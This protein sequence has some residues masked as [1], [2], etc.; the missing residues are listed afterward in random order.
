MADDDKRRGIGA[1]EILEPQRRFQ[2][3]VVRRFVQQQ[4]F[5]LGKQQCA[6]RDAHL[7]PAGKALDRALLHLF[8]EAQTVEDLGRAGRRA[9]GIDRQQAVMHIA[10]PVHV[11]AGFQL[12]QQF[13]A[14][15]SRSEHDFLG[16]HRAAG[17]FLRDIAD[18]RARRFGD[19]PVIGFDLADQGLHQRRLARA[20]A[21]DQ[22][23]ARADRHRRTGAFENGPAAKPHCDTVD[24]KHARPLN[25]QLRC[26]QRK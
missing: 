22:P 24:G 19:V 1:K 15:G 12:G 16:R 10:H 6:E 2:I 17:R 18:P 26:A 3:E 14:F 20:V 4:D 11:G 7:P 23:D 9:V 8:V 25:S 13:G 21:A 5:R